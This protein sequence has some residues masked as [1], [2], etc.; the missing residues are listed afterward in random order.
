[1]LAIASYGSLYESYYE[2]YFSNISNICDG[3]IGSYTR[4]NATRANT[5]LHIFGFDFST[6][7][8]T[9]IINSITIRVLRSFGA[10]GTANISVWESALSQRGN[11]SITIGSGSTSIDWFSFTDNTL[12]PSSLC[13]QWSVAELKSGL[14]RVRI[15]ASSTSSVLN[16]RA[17]LYEVEVSVNYTNPDENKIYFGLDEVKEIKLS[18]NNIKKVYKGDNLVFEN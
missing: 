13:G 14:F 15:G 18:T 2:D 16:G 5:P 8:D 11:G 4:Y 7:P 9:S 10:F 6:L 3:N 1:M 12:S 17:D